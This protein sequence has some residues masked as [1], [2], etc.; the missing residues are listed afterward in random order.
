MLDVGTGSGILTIAAKKLNPR[1]SV[2]ACDNDPLAVEAA[3]E[4]FI[5]NQVSSL[6]LFVGEPRTIAAQFDL[7]IA[8]LTAVIIQ[9]LASEISRLAR[10]YVIVAGFTS[11][12]GPSVLES[13]KEEF[14]LLRT[15]SMNGWLCYKL[16]SWQES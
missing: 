3:H 6:R 12:Q 15:F 5:N 1:L 16:R 13:L 14:E 4:N 10:N 8:N 9:D 7:V 11:E 2:F